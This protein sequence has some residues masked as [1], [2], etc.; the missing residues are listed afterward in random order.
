MTRR[1]LA[2]D[3]AWSAVLT[4]LV[5]GPVLIRRG[6]AL[7]G[8]MVFV[9]D[10]PWKDAWLGLD[11]ATP[12]FVP[13]EAVV[14][15]LTLPIPGDLVQKGLLAAALLLT[16]LGGARLV[17]EL[18][19]AA[20]WT[21]ATVLLWNPWVLG[22]LEIGQ[23]PLLV[24]YAT[25]P[26]LVLAVRRVRR[27]GGGAL[28]VL[29]LA[30]SAAASPPSGLLAL[31]LVVL[32]CAGTV[33]LRRT[34]L[35]AGSG[36][37]LNLPWIAP[38]VLL[39]HQLVA[40]PEQFT[41]FALRGESG[42]GALASAL[43]L[44]GIWKTSIVAPERG[45]ELVIALGVVLAGAALLGL[46]VV[47]ATHRTDVRRLLGAGAVLLVLA[48]A[49]SLDPVGEALGGAAG[50]V[51]ALGLLRDSHR[52]VAPWALVLALGLAGLVA[53]VERR[54]VPGREAWRLVAATGVVLPALL[55]PSLAWGA[56]GSLDPVDY[57]AEW[58]EV[59]DL[60]AATTVVLPWHGTYRGFGWNE[61]RAML[62]PAPRMFP[63][64]VLIDDRH[65]LDD[66]VVLESEEPLLARVAIALERPGAEE[67]ADALRGLG[68][69]RVV[70]ERG[71]GV[72]DA[73]MPAGE[74]VH[75]GPDLL[76]VDLA[77]GGEVAALGRPGPPRAIVIAADV[78]ALLTLA[79][80]F[81]SYVARRPR[82]GYRP[83]SSRL[84][85]WEGS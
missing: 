30:V 83:R 27:G 12:R 57:P 44:G 36:V 9:P 66:G 62:D 63:G 28:V 61:R 73:A 55:L 21:A 40:S 14:W 74:V 5:L 38:A 65:F 29:L 70:L 51:P 15:L 8:D 45:S 64:T 56:D 33:P 67:R 84:R 2:L 76:V 24:G 7:V 35:L 69:E 34:A 26:W 48:V 71:N 1:D 47:A 77:S 11:G 10:Q 78:V 75:D 42:L 72:D 20:R 3:A 54:A 22:R 79:G 58:Y 41:A 6:Y 49:T 68:I 18:G 81:V 17:A 46:R 60:P 31:G 53:S 4:F 39:P 52:L 80:W 25:L 50:E 43:S 23:W 82:M 16:A 37:L 59:Q 13:G 85:I 32:L 19:L